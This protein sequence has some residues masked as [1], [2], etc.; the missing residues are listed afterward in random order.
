MSPFPSTQ[1]D[2]E[3]DSLHT[4]F[5]K[6]SASTCIRPQSFH[7][8]FKAPCSLCFQS[9]FPPS[10]Y[11]LWDSFSCGV[12]KCTNLSFCNI[13]PAI[14]PI[15]CGFLKKILDIIVFTSGFLI[16]IFFLFLRSYFSLLHTIFLAHME[17]RCFNVLSA[18][19]SIYIISSG[20]VATD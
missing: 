3:L 7:V 9:F 20:S 10:V 11:F 16:W 14:N 4:N 2:L 1:D 5:E 13:S 6:L 19:S 15:Q 8:I 12:I 18:N 17:H